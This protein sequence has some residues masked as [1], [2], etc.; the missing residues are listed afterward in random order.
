VTATIGKAK[1]GVGN[2]KAGKRTTAKT[3]KETKVTKDRRNA[4]TAETSDAMSVAETEQAAISYLTQSY[5]STGATTL[6]NAVRV[7]PD[8]FRAAE[9]A[10]GVFARRL[11]R[12]ELNVIF[13]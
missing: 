3:R 13:R 1:G 11:I 10:V 7:V 8:H 4:Y 5:G 9:N 6:L 12:H 2:A